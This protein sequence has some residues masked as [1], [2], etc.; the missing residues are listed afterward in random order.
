VYRGHSSIA[1]T[2]DGDFITYA[3]VPNA[4]GFLLF[5]AAWTI[6]VVILQTL[7]RDSFAD[8]AWMS[9]FR[10]GAEV[11]AVLSWFAG[12]VAVAVNTGTEACS[13][14]Y[15]SCGTLK[16]ATVF[17]AAEWLLFMVTTTLAFSLF[18]NSKRQQRTSTV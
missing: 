11:L 8:R 4:W 3:G 10:V 5:C 6:L 17:G 18:L 13:E 15:T 14:G 12:W 7:A 9:Y 1:H 16:A 2:P